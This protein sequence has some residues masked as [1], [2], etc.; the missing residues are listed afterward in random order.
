MLE[1][2]QP[3]EEKEKNPGTYTIGIAQY[4]GSLEIKYL[5]YNCSMLDIKLEM[6]LLLYCDINV[7]LFVIAL[8][9]CSKFVNLQLCL[10]RQTVSMRRLLAGDKY[11]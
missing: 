2:S 6:I 8:C 5:F 4:L 10:E 3:I 9:S 7:L 11:I 1:T